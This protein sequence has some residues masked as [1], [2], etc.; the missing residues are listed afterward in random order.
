MSPELKK[1]MEK[2]GR[3]SAVKKLMTFPR[4]N[5]EP[6]NSLE[7]GFKSG[8]EW[9]HEQEVVPLLVK[10]EKARYALSFLELEADV[11]TIKIGEKI[12]NSHELIAETLK[13]IED[14]K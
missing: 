10:L 11:F 6:A 2:E 3:G 14:I 5:W 7:S 8:A 4:A 1:R 12:I 13:E 9:M